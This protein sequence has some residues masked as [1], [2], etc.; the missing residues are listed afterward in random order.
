[1]QSNW[2]WKNE[3]RLLIAHGCPIFP[4]KRNCTEHDRRAGNGH[5]DTD[6]KQDA[7]AAVIQDDPAGQT[8]DHKSGFSGT[9]LQSLCHHPVMRTHSLVGEIDGG[10]RVERIGA[11]LHSV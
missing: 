5:D 11:D 1:M 2:R 8:A 10:D 6:P 9:D 3:I 4:E 7:D